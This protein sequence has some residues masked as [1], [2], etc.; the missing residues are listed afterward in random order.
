MTDTAVAQPH[1]SLVPREFLVLWQPTAAPG[2]RCVGTLRREPSEYVFTYSAEG[3]TNEVFPGFA[4][5]PD[6][7]VDYRSPVLFPLFAS[8]VMTPRRDGYE[9]YLVALGLHD[10]SPDPF[11]VLERT[12]GVTATDQIQV[13][14]VPE[15]GEG[16]RLSFRFLV[17]GARHVDPLGERLARVS[18]GSALR[19]VQERDN[20]SSARAVLVGDSLPL[21]RESALGYVPDVLAGLVTTLLDTDSVV[22]VWAEHVNHVGSVDVPAQLRLLVRVEAVVP[23]HF[24]VRD[25]LRLPGALSAV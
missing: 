13:L 5:F 11:V 21:T 6:R 22:Q 23:T 4:N 9:E 17:H 8:R 14:P 1:A 16:G 19:L 24:D 20:P 10:M 12:L 18:P 15:V 2:Y 3:R 25:A 7:S